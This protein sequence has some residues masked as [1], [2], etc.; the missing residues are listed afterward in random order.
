MHLKILKIFQTKTMV[1][2]ESYVCAEFPNFFIIDNNYPFILQLQLSVW[3]FSAEAFTEAKPCSHLQLRKCS[4]SA[5]FNQCQLFLN[6]APVYRDTRKAC[7]FPLQIGKCSV[8]RGYGEVLTE[9]FV[10]S[11]IPILIIFWN[12]ACLF[13]CTR[14]SVGLTFYVLPIQS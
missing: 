11:P 1:F 14:H 7:L 2:L 12:R 3:I 13:F 6:K 9:A 5:S 8:C 10:N 4:I